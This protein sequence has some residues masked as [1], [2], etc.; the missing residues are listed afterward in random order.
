MGGGIRRRDLLRQSLAV[1]GAAAIGPALM[2]LGPLAERAG[3]APPRI[4]NGPYG[5]LQPSGADGVQ[6]PAG[7]EVREIARGNVPLGTTGYVW[8]PFPDGSGSFPQPDGSR[9]APWRPMA[10]ARSL[11][12]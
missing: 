12:G 10:S 5:P 6:V 8:P 9:R 4:T 1:G 7:F 3:G 2:R 11:T